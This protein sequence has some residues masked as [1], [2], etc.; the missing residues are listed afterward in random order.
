MNVKEG[1][2]KILAEA[3]DS[4]TSGT[5]A[6]AALGVSRNAVWKAVKALEAEGYEIESVKSRGYRIAESSNRLSQ[7]LISAKLETVRLGRSLVV[8]GETDSTNNYAKKLASTGAVHGTTVVADQQTAGKGRLGR[9]FISPPGTGLYMSVIVRPEFGLD[10]AAMITAAAACAAAE[11][12]EALCGQSVRIKWVNDLYMNGRK[13]CGILTEASLGLEMKSLDYAVIGIGINVG[14]VGDAFG[15]ELSRIA[16][17][18]EDETGVRI[19]RS[20]LCA[21]LLGRLEFYLGK[22][23]TRE[24]LPEYRRREMLTGHEVTAQ[25][26]GITLTGRAI[27]VDDNANLM[28][29]LPDGSERHLSSGEANLL[30]IKR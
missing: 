14:R 29:L 12:V 15:E 3:G 2:M 11:A 17:S 18:I 25:V 1:L 30:R 13:I 4:F 19:S 8:L 5:A 9:A 16:T 7:E 28:I 6:A 27:G 20:A 23:V 21:E 10:A 26:G 22:V 24:F